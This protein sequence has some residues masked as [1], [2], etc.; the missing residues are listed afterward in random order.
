MSL[1]PMGIESSITNKHAGDSSPC[2]ESRVR[3]GVVI[4]VGTGTGIASGVPHGRV[5]RAASSAWTQRQGSSSSSSP[6]FEVVHEPRGSCRR[7]DVDAGTPKIHRETYKSQQ[8][9]MKP[10]CLLAAGAW[11][12][13]MHRTFP[14]PKHAIGRLSPQNSSH[15]SQSGHQFSR[16]IHAISEIKQFIS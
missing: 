9:G 16:H 5:Q 11:C 2:G 8:G 4:Q 10:A 13:R 7:R 3:R 14:P 12:G 6:K 15:V 1:L